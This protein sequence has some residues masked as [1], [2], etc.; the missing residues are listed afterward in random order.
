MV[1]SSIRTYF[2]II[3]GYHQKVLTDFD[4]SMDTFFLERIESNLQ[5]LKELYATIKWS[6]NDHDKNY[7]S[8]AEFMYKQAKDAYSA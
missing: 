5:A 3:N 2:Q 4:P 8:V 7:L 1:N 6:T